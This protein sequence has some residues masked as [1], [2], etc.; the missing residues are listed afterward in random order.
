[1]D[2]QKQI[3]N[4]ALVFSESSIMQAR[5]SDAVP[6]L[7]GTVQADLPLLLD[8]GGHMGSNTALGLHLRNCVSTCSVCDTACE[9]T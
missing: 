4:C 5:R 7:T 6:A 3:N 8:R 1:M 9:H 2:S